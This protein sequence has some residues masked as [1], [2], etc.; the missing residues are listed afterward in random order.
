MRPKAIL[1][2]QRRRSF[3]PRRR[4]FKSTAQKSMKKNELMIPF[5]T[6]VI[7]K[8]YWKFISHRVHKEHRVFSFYFPLFVIQKKIKK[9]CVLCE[10]CVKQT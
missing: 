3:K 4:F 7:S 2:V 5:S 1:S 10:L 6:F 8:T 9:L